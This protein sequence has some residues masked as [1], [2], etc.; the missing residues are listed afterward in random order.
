VTAALWVIAVC[1]V[2]RVSL[3]VCVELARLR[4]AARLLP[5]ASEAVGP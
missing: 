2:A 5:L 4:Q 3:T 1:Q